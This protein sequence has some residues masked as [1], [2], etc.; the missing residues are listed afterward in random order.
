[1]FIEAFKVLCTLHITFV[2][3]HLIAKEKNQYPYKVAKKKKV[4]IDAL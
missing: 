2:R 4:Q 3:V 1:M